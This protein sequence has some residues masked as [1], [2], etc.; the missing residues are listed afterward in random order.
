MKKSTIF[1]FI[2]LIAFTLLT[3]VISISAEEITLGVALSIM[4]IA[5]IKFLLVAFEFMELKK[6]NGMWKLAIVG[7]CVLSIGV[8]GFFVGMN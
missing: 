7:L 4:G 5:G 3:A 2:T 1:T 8:V 6:A